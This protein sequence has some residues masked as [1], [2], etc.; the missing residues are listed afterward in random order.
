[1]EHWNG[2]KLWD[3]VVSELNEKQREKLL[4]GVPHAQNVNFEELVGLIM[5][6]ENEPVVYNRRI[7]EVSPKKMDWNAIPATKR[8]E[9]EEG[10]LSVPRIDQWF[11]MQ[12]DPD[13]CDRK[14]QSFHDRYE[15]FRKVSNTPDEILEGL[16]VDLGGPDFRYDSGLANAVYAVVVYFFDRCDIFEDPLA[17]TNDGGRIADANSQLPESN[18]Q[19]KLATDKL[20]QGAFDDFT[21]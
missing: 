3:D 12:G 20:I 5:N 8:A 21:D 4:P 13:L 7:G 18:R 10:R 1:M 16:Y 19:E 17:E 6:I 11:A 9:F 14:A 2:Q 15:Y